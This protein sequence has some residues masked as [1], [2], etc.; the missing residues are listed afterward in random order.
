MHPRFRA[1][2]KP[3][4]QPGGGGSSEN[5]KI[6]NDEAKKTKNKNRMIQEA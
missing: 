5:G 4:P 3:F 2:T 1:K 6:A